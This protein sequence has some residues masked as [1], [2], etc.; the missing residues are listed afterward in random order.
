MCRGRSL[1]HP[2]LVSAKVPQINNLGWAIGSANLPG[3]FVRWPE[4][5]PDRV[6]EAKGAPEIRRAGKACGKTGGATG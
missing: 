3:D 1:F 6:S 4:S 2:S 5:V